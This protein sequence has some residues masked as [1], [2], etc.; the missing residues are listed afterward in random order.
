VSIHA[1]WRKRD[2]RTVY[3]VRLRDPSGREYRR[4]FPTKR[5]AEAFQAKERSD[6]SRGAWIDPRRA[7]TTF[8]EVANAW[9]ESDPGKSEGSR[10]RDEGIVRNHL[11]P[12]LEKRPVGSINPRDAQA[13]VSRWSRGQAPR[14]V[15]RQYDVLR[16]IL[17]YAVASDMLARSPCRNI[18]LPKASVSRRRVLNNRQLA[19]L[20]EAVGEP[21]GPMVYMG[22]VLGLRWGECAGLR[23]ADLDFLA[24]TVTVSGQRTRGTGGRMIDGMPKSIAGRRTLSAP[25][26]LMDLLAAHL[27]N[28]QLTAADCDAYVFVGRRGRPLQYSGFRQRVWLRACREVGL[29]DLGFHDLRRTNATTMVVKGVDVKTAQ[30]RLG[31]SDPRLTLG[32]Y[33]QATTDADRAAADLLAELLDGS[34]D[35]HET[36]ARHGRGMEGA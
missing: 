17:N 6:R 14:T 16:A 7:E 32:I 3:N 11:N 28:R 21:H 35:T 33:A 1:Q 4:T 23:V 13:L 26:S 2:G 12:A 27:K 24:R 36:S 5:A 31:H 10:S 8:G 30:A 9:L 25:R 20:A 18:K 29:Q 19:E 34:D 22:A 15:S